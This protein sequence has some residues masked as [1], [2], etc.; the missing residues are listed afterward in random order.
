MLRTTFRAA[1]VARCCRCVLSSPM[2]RD[3]R[4]PMTRTR[5]RD[6]SLNARSRSLDLGKFLRLFLFSPAHQS[7][8][9]LPRTNRHGRACMANGLGTTRSRRTQLA[10]LCREL[11]LDHLVLPVVNSRCPP[12]AGVPFW[13][14]CLLL[15]PVD[16][17][18]TGIE[19]LF[20]TGRPSVIRSRWT[21]QVNVIVT[22]ALD[23]ELGVDITSI[24]QMLLGQE[25][26]AFK[27]GMNRGG[28]GV[29]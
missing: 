20:L 19:A 2:E 11:D 12:D 18:V 25:C 16:E 28:H 15:L 24:H 1:A 5:L 26:F 10:V 23:Q 21:D 4:K 27:L 6:G 8:V 9:L 22:L 14:R 29:V 3:R 17:K 13:T 7:L